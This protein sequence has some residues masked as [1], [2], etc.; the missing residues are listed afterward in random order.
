LQGYIF[1]TKACIDSHPHTCYFCQ[2]Y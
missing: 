2:T 1:A